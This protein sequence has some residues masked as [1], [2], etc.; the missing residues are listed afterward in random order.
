[1]SGDKTNAGRGP[2]GFSW[3]PLLDR[4]EIEAGSARTHLC[5]AGWRSVR[6]TLPDEQLHMLVAG[7]AEYDI[8]GLRYR[9]R[10]GQIAFCPPGVGWSARNAGQQG[11]RLMVV[12]FQARFPGG[13]RFLDAFGF[14]PVVTPG[15]A[16]FR[17]LREICQRL[18]RLYE[19]PSSGALLMRKA[20]MHEFFYL[21]FPSRGQATPGDRHGQLVLRLIGF[22]EEHYREPITMEALSSRAALSANHL[23]SVFRRY[24]GRGPIDFLIHL[25]LGKAGQLLVAGDRSIQEIAW[26]VGYEDAA[27]FSR[28]FRRHTGMSPSQ[29]RKQGGSTL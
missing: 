23:A 6:R 1:M 20:L 10:Q 22:L 12:H 17:R 15:S 7:R 26:E 2:G 16:V 9:A 4:L 25:R 11:L 3:E 28:L 21:L 14:H 29:Y 5:R 19:K 24:T 27:Y 8:D 18:C 13:L